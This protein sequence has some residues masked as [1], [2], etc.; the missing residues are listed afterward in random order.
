V[1]ARGREAFVYLPATMTI[2][3]ATCHPLPERDPDWDPLSAAL[4]AARLQYAWHAWDD[5]A[6][7]WREAPLVVVRSTWDYIHRLDAF[8]SWADA[9]GARLVNPAPMLRWNAHK[10]Y[11]VELAG[12]GLPV[13]PTEL[14]RVGEPTTLEEVLVETGWRDVVV[15]PA[16]S[17]GSFR[18]RRVRADTLEAEDASFFAALSLERDVLVQPYLKSV[19][20]YGERS[21]V[22]VDGAVTHAIRKTARFDGQTESVSDTPQPIAPEERAFAERTL[23]AVRKRFGELPFYARVDTARDEDG[24]VRLMELEL[25]EPSLFFEQGPEALDLFVE[26][27]RRRLR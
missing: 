10:G 12:E 25:I 11:L 21:L 14:V 22:T 26:G 18:T 27:L 8:L 19:E 6:A 17:A 23:A 2:L 5:H 4:D 16:V 20:G 1:L 24:S 7:P 9:L 13:V 15:K 3:L